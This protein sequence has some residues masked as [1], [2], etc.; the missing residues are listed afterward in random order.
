MVESFIVRG[1]LYIEVHELI[2]SSWTVDSHV[3]ATLVTRLR[4]SPGSRLF[5]VACNR[6]RSAERFN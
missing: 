5:A 3:L 6:V 1:I 4:G 2:E